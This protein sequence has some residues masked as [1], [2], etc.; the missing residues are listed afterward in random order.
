MKKSPSPYEIVVKA[1]DEL[2]VLVKHTRNR[3]NLNL[4]DAAQESN[5]PFNVLSRIENGKPPSI[6][7]FRKILIWISS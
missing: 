3:K 2:P 5:V 7:N 6:E 4:R 1:I